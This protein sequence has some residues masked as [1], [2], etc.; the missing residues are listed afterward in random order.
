MGISNTRFDGGPTKFAEQS[1]ILGSMFQT[2]EKQHSE[3][4][5]DAL[6]EAALKQNAPASSNHRSSG[7]PADVRF[8]GSAQGDDVELHAVADEFSGS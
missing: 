4:L 3:G 5:S 7:G 1:Q 8:S 2:C 6:K